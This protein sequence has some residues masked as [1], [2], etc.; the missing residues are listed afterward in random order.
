MQF[1]LG[2]GEYLGRFNSL[3]Y[4]T[5]SSF[6]NWE[7]IFGDIVSNDFF[8]FTV[9]HLFQRAVSILPFPITTHPHNTV[10]Y[11]LSIPSLSHRKRCVPVHPGSYESVRRS[12]NRLHH[13]ICQAQPD[14]ENCMSVV[15]EQ[16]FSIGIPPF[17]SVYIL[18]QN[19]GLK[20]KWIM[21][22]KCA[23]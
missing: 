2:G 21:F 20:Y 10:V 15:R 17:R 13:R 18:F 16:Y 3:I 23:L 19:W 9:K 6:S 4:P 7:A 5:Q 8:T 11:T 12:E 1:F 14:A 22:L